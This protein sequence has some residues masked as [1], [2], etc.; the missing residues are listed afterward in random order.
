[1]I[2]G[3]FAAHGGVLLQNFANVWIATKFFSCFV[4][5]DFPHKAEQGYLLT[6]NFAY[7]SFLFLFF[8]LL[9][10]TSTIAATP[11]KTTTP[12]EHQSTITSV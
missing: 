11:L 3:I 4:F 8:L 5:R 10:A 1:M 7:K 2:Y 12:T 9:T 6:E